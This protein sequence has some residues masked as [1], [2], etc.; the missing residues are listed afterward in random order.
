MRLPHEETVALTNKRWYVVMASCLINL[1]LGS[2]YTWS[3]FSPPMAMHLN[4]INGFNGSEALS[5]ATL[6]VVFSMA[7]SIGAIMILLGGYGYDRFG[8]RL[9]IF[10]GGIF[11]GGGML[12]SGYATSLN[13][14]TLAYGGGL[15]IGNGFVYICTI[16]NSVKLFPDKRGLVGG[17][18]TASYGLSSFILP[19]IASALINSSGVENAFKILGIAFIVIISGSSFLVTRCP[20]DFV[21]AGWTP[22][23][24]SLTGSETDGTDKNWKQMLA[25]P[26][27]YVML[28]MLMCGGVFGL[29]IISQ[30]SSLSQN[31]TGMSV[32]AAT[33]VVSI[34]ALF[35]AAGR[36]CAGSISDKIGRVNT[37]SLMLVVAIV[38]LG[39]LYFCGKGDFIIFYTGISVVGLCFGAFMGVYP[40]F[41][42][43]QF[44]TKYSGFNYSIMFIGFGLSAIIGPTVM[45]T[46]YNSS[47]SYQNAFLIAASLSVLGI[48]LSFIYRTMS[49]VK[50]VSA[51]AHQA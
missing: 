5:A 31:I 22:T 3:V 36:V 44:G 49:K 35:N 47:G 37:L 38:G 48:A 9:M 43:D 33:T 28:I 2:M 40:G 27:F 45:T 4:T 7:N 26:I 13:M 18:I 15:G 21:P 8:P 23:S 51:L 29:M 46:V 25:D 34:L 19:P 42:A 16:S 41:T 20:D 39:L 6:A 30:A 24:N 10:L 1:C 11:F 50:K 12:L 14:L 32:T 17:I